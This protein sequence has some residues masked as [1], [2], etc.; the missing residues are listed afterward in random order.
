MNFIS[1]IHSSNKD[2]NHL[3]K[4][5]ASDIALPVEKKVASSIL[6]SPWALF[7][8][9]LQSKNLVEENHKVTKDFVNFN[10]L[11]LNVE[12]I[13]FI[14]DYWQGEEKVY[15]KEL[16]ATVSFVRRELIEHL[17]RLRL[18]DPELL[19]MVGSGVLKCCGYLYFLNHFFE[20]LEID[21]PDLSQESLALFK[22]SFEAINDFDFRV[23]LKKI[24]GNSLQE[25]ELAIR[26]FFMTKVGQ[27]D[28]FI[29]KGV[30]LLKTKYPKR[31][32]D[33]SPASMDA[34]E[35]VTMHFFIKPVAIFD[36]SEDMHLYKLGEMDLVVY[37]KIGRG[38][39]FTKR[40]LELPMDFLL[41]KECTFLSPY[42][43]VGDQAQVFVDLIT[44][45]VRPSDPT[46]L[47]ASDWI[48]AVVHLTK[49]SGTSKE[50]LKELITAFQKTPKSLAKQLSYCQSHLPRSPTFQMALFWNALFSID[51]KETELLSQIAGFIPKISGSTF[52]GRLLELYRSGKVSLKL[53][54]SLLYCLAHIHRDFFLEDGA[55]SFAEI[56]CRGALHL[57]E[58]A[59]FEALLAEL[60]SIQE[61]SIKQT[62]LTL[63]EESFMHGKSDL[64]LALRKQI[65]EQACLFSNQKSHFLNN[66][67]LLLLIFANLKVEDEAQRKKWLIQLPC[68]FLISSPPLL[69]EKL[70]ALENLLD[71]KE[72]ILSSLGSKDFKEAAFAIITSESFQDICLPTWKAYHGVELTEWSQSL[73]EHLKVDFPHYSC[74]ILYHLYVK[75]FLESSKAWES[76]KKIAMPLLLEKGE[77]IFEKLLGK[78]AQDQKPPLNFSIQ[79]AKWVIDQHSSLVMAKFF[80]NPQLWQLMTS[81]MAFSEILLQACYFG[82]KNAEMKKKGL[83]IAQELIGLMKED[84]QKIHAIYKV[85][86]KGP[87]PKKE[88]KCFI[89]RSVEFYRANV[90]LIDSL[91]FFDLFSS[92]A[93]CQL[94]IALLEEKIEKNYLTEAK[95]LTKELMQDKAACSDPKFT[96]NV[97]AL[98]RL[99]LTANRSQDLESAK[100][101][102]KHPLL[103]Q[104][105]KKTSASFLV[106]LFN[107]ELETFQKAHTS[108]KNVQ[109]QL[110]DTVTLIKRYLPWEEESSMALIATFANS[111]RL[112]LEC[113]WLPEASYHDRQRNLMAPCLYKMLGSLFAVDR[114]EA[115]L[116]L[117]HQ[118]H[119]CLFF[120]DHLTE[121]LAGLIKK[122]I[123][124]QIVKESFSFSKA[125]PFVDFIDKKTLQLLI[126][127]KTVGDDQL[128]VFLQKV[129][130]NIIAELG[131]DFLIPLMV[132]HQE[133][134]DEG[135]LKK[136]LQLSFSDKNWGEFWNQRALWLFEKD[137]E[138]FIELCAV[139]PI[140]YVPEV[141][142][143]LVKEPVISQ[144]AITLITKMLKSKKITSRDLE[145]SISPRILLELING[146]ELS[147]ETLELFQEVAVLVKLR[148]QK[149]ALKMLLLEK[150]C[151]SPFS[152]CL[153]KC[154]TMCFEILHFEDLPELSKTDLERVASR[155]LKQIKAPTLPLLL[156]KG[157][158]GY[159]DKRSTI[160]PSFFFTSLSVF[161]NAE[162]RQ[163]FFR[164]IRLFTQFSMQIAGWDNATLKE[165]EAMLASFIKKMSY[166]KSSFLSGVVVK[167]LINDHG[168]FNRKWDLEKFL[169]SFRR[170]LEARLFANFQQDSKLSL[171]ETICIFEKNFSLLTKNLKYFN[172]LVEGIFKAYI[173]LL[174]RGQQPQNFNALL[175][176]IYAFWEQRLIYKNHLESSSISEATF[177]INQRLIDFISDNVK[178]KSDNDKVR[179]AYYLLLKN[180]K[181]CLG[182]SDCSNKLK[183][184]K[185]SYLF[186][187]HFGHALRTQYNLPDLLK[188]L[189][190]YFPQEAYL[191]HPFAY[192]CIEHYSQMTNAPIPSKKIEW[193]RQ[194]R[195]LK[196]SVVEEVM[197]QL[198][199]QDLALCYQSALSYL[200][201]YQ[202]LLP[203]QRIL[204]GFY[205]KIFSQMRNNVLRKECW[206]KAY[207]NF[208]NNQVLSLFFLDNYLEIGHD[209]FKGLYHENDKAFD[210]RFA[211]IHDIHEAMDLLDKC[212]DIVEQCY[213]IV[214]QHYLH[215]ENSNDTL[216]PHLQNL[217]VM[218]R[219]NQLLKDTL[220][221]LNCPVK[222]SISFIE[223][224]Q[225]LETA[226]VKRALKDNQEYRSLIA[227]CFRQAH[228]QLYITDVER[229]YKLLPDE[230]Q[231]ISRMD[232]ETREVFT[233]AIACIQKD[234]I[235][236]FKK[237]SIDW[238]LL[239][240][241][242]LHLACLGRAE[243]IAMWLIEQDKALL[244]V[245]GNQSALEIAAIQGLSE[246]TGLLLYKSHFDLSNIDL[247][248]AL[249]LATMRLASDKAVIIFTIFEK[250]LDPRRFF[251]VCGSIL[252]R[253][254]QA[255]IHIAAKS[256]QLEIFKW[257]L[258]HGHSP[259]VGDPSGNTPLH[260]IVLENQKKKGSSYAQ[261]A[262]LALQSGADPFLLNGNSESPLRIAC[263]YG[264][265]AI[266]AQLLKKKELLFF[267]MRICAQHGFTKGFEIL[268]QLTLEDTSF[269]EKT[270]RDLL[271]QKGRDGRSL[272]HQ[273]CFFGHNKIAQLA[274]ENGADPLLRSAKD[275]KEDRNA[276]DFALTNGHVGIAKRLFED[277]SCPQRIF[278]DEEIVFPRNG[279]RSPLHWATYNDSN[280]PLTRQLLNFGYRLDVVNEFQETPLHFAVIN[281]NPKI[282][283]IFLKFA[284]KR[285]MLPKIIDCKNYLGETSLHYAAR[286]G[287]RNLIEILLKYKPSN[288]KN[289]HNQY[290]ADSAIEA[291]HSA[292]GDGLKLFFASA[293]HRK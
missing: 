146:Q 118:L 250:G 277:L 157:L 231:G 49:G 22:E 155:Y 136:L 76:L 117:L 6:K 236:A 95:S 47:A 48:Q 183:L 194:S 276:L 139:L 275:V 270:L 145:E 144:A 289:E 177:G 293:K 8:A 156:G 135:F 251:E 124:S 104:T 246:L 198:L 32:K 115:G 10:W 68:L 266:L 247:A 108:P 264:D 273:A 27:S 5:S 185:T 134:L 154:L 109:Q 73:I 40:S 172:R 51:P 171:D 66:V 211:V 12:A 69:K 102:F 89:E 58:D 101:I 147:L 143:E 13:D 74:S 282:L 11:N 158:D 210:D 55:V 151:Q 53:L 23:P 52:L 221:L 1:G 81:G 220:Q 45:Y 186:D 168:V 271:N 256:Q 217:L 230:F 82:N 60:D 44:N 103:G 92:S 105:H 42:S 57:F 190:S 38:S 187:M 75:G 216:T 272:L 43:L 31:L 269:S 222:E 175:D 260:Y 281:K 160:D 28:E 224:Y 206:I 100:I 188:V 4:I 113:F 191:D 292:I 149:V 125:V 2:Y 259:N 232:R 140:E 65:F 278:S 174:S 239:A 241:N 88:K 218:M 130:F 163:S 78:L 127:H 197:E 252:P 41:K 255:L 284:Q 37:A 254:N 132:K 111:Y 110:F 285:G 120:K 201:Q 29:K 24:K 137:K 93:R 267:A 114:E 3:F 71:I 83:G 192:F 150:F 240:A 85:L 159:L 77:L 181:F 199:L 195:A 148:D 15:S 36:G 133:K 84:P 90:D 152:E 184:F 79:L 129:N 72:G 225:F 265:G 180:L 274:L 131:S 18:I 237:I 245:V 283:C 178:R 205:E 176:K 80:K 262:A 280:A 268:L 138:G 164:S 238:A 200:L 123:Q 287:G 20:V 166:T 64:S 121:D 286:I 279:I 17:A 179:P 21:P 249:G 116:E 25:C 208:E 19:T 223:L 128:L 119:V 203:N 193:E 97:L 290:P 165:N 30:S 106:D 54:H 9:L 170:S 235:N 253:Y 14:K 182:K 291:G 204:E 202:Q 99:L 122:L 233:S 243:K 207:A 248:Y 162:D 126:D 62:I 107:Q 61:L 226:P 214:T 167:A 39:R 261:M 242:P 86:A 189:Q 234:D 35:L 63:M 196:L 59:T 56:S 67:G 244:K 153:E 91:N 161:F 70:E 212:Q 141:I 213:R 288:L 228:E 142:K 98:V 263:R 257:L 7:K 26:Q 87:F 173:T 16:D 46:K 33:L 169:P 112:F 219:M 34:V 96:E 227:T 94:K 215:W 258:E 229:L 50:I 209:Y